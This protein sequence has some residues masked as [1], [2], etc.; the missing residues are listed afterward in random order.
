MLK[1]SASAFDPS[2]TSCVRRGGVAALIRAQQSAI[3]VIGFLNSAAAGPL[4]PL[5]RAFL[6]GLR[7][8]GFVEGRNVAIEYRWAGVN[9]FDCRRWQP[10]LSR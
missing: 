2:A 10:S 4:A 7:E 1:V 9:L 8:A 6:D 5:T 3:P